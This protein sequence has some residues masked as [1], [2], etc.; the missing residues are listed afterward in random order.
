VVGGGGAEAVSFTFIKMEAAGN[1]DNPGD[2]IILCSVCDHTDSALAVT[3][4]PTQA[5]TC[6]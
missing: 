4:T 3:C 2:I 5:C 1:I 6:L